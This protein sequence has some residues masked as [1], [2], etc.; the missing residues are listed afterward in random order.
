MKIHPVGAM[1]F[2]PYRLTD[3]HDKAK[4]AFRNFA[5]TP[6]KRRV[7]LLNKVFMSCTLISNNGFFLVRVMCVIQ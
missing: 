1:L 5:N 6:I 3:R 7:F 2:N 4:A